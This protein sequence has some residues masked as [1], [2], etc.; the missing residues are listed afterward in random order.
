MYICKLNFDV[1]ISKQH[2]LA[3]Y[4][5]L[6]TFCSHSTHFSAVNTIHFCTKKSHISYSLLGQNFNLGFSV[7]IIV[8]FHGIDFFFSIFCSLPFAGIH[9]FHFQMASTFRVSEYKS[10]RPGNEKEACWCLSLSELRNITFENKHPVAK[11]L[12]NICS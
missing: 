5:N 7:S 3:L 12:C 8:L 10:F 2:A 11:H 6:A 9:Y 1:I 4:V